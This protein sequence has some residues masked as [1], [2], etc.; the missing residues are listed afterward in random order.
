MKATRDTAAWTAAGVLAVVLVALPLAGLGWLPGGVLPIY[1]VN[2]IG[3]VMS[4][5]LLAMSVDLMWGGAGVLSLGHGLFFAFGGYLC[6]MHL[7]RTAYAATHVLPDF[8]LFMGHGGFPSWWHFADSAAV[9]A[10]AVILLPAGLAFVFGYVSF[11]SRVNGVYFSII[12]Q[13]LTYTAMLLMFRNDTGFGGN[14]GMTGFHAIAGLPAGSLGAAVLL[15]GLATAAV[16]LALVLGRMMLGSRFGRLLTAIRDDEPRLRFLG[17]DTLW[18]KLAAWCLSASMA[19]VA[20]ALYVPQVGIINPSLLDPSLSLEVAVW[21]AV[22]G[23]G[24]LLGAVIGAT[25]VNLLKF[26]LSA[27]APELWPFVLSLLGLLVVLVLPNGLLDVRNR[28][29]EWMTD[30]ARGPLPLLRRALR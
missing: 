3:Q 5:S 14:N 9:T 6:A 19:A 27:A 2:L 11:R 10:I 30:L 1:A 28:S 13:A 4:L 25:L 8:L 16:L 17:Y 22:G 7:L 15:A 23:R 12:T 21:V 18:L 24:G 26:W 20:G 29:R